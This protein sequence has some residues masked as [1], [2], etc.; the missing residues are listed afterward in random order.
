MRALQLRARRQFAM[1]GSV[2]AAP[3][4]FVRQEQATIS[5]WERFAGRVTFAAIGVFAA[6]L[7][8]EALVP[9]DG[10]DS[11]WLGAAAAVIVV[12]HRVGFWPSAIV[13]FGTAATIQLAAANGTGVHG[14]VGDAAALVLFLV[15]ALLGAS[16]VA[17]RS[18]RNGAELVAAGTGTLVEPLT[19]R[20]REIL[21][22]LAIGLS[23]R[24]IAERLVVS[25]NTIKTHLEHLYGK[26]EVPS[27]LR[28][29]ARARELGL[30]RDAPVGERSAQ[31]ARR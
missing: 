30:L 19:D 24:E 29:I 2:L 8:I 11:V 14:G 4:A 15:V 10:T 18:R 3:A 27:R 22:L 31:S 17:G 25:E 16:S 7:V 13:A 1:P 12:A 23:N 20:E 9:G 6:V 28:A 26:L 5:R 21:G